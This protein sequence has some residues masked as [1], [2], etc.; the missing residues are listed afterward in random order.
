[1]ALKNYPLDKDVL[2]WEIQDRQTMASQ[3]VGW[4]YPS[5]LNGEI[6]E[7]EALLQHAQ[8][9]DR[10]FVHF[11][12][13]AET[14]ARC[15]PRVERNFTE[16]SDLVTCPQCRSTMDPIKS[17]YQRLM[18]SESDQSAE[19]EGDLVSALPAAKPSI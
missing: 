5:I 6:A 17:R 1:M 11:W 16:L 12:P 2:R 10:P 19:S 7:L 18:G 9:L 3:C 8:A 15:H 4:L 13:K 14:V